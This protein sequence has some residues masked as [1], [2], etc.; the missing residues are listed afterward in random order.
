MTLFVSTCHI[1]RRFN[2]FSFDGTVVSIY[3][4]IHSDGLFLY[5]LHELKF[6]ASIPFNFMGLL[7]FLFSSC[8]KD[9][10]DS[11]TELCPHEVSRFQRHF[12]HELPQGLS[13]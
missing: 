13:V 7:H 9:R 11:G 6:P 8:S 12:C 3:C 10:Q 4:R 1:I 2:I 5:H